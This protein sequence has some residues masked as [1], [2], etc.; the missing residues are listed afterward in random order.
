MLTRK[1]GKYEFQTYVHGLKLGN[2]LTTTQDA[3][4]GRKKDIFHSEN[5]IVIS[6]SV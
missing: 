6:L 4:S 2:F 5:R 1:V 3:K